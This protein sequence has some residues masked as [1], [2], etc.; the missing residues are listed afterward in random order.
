MGEEASLWDCAYSLFD[1]GQTCG[2]D[3]AVICQGNN[4]D[5]AWCRA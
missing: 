5:N 4:T 1:I 3:A 2:S